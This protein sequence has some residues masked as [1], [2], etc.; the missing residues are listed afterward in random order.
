MQSD[1]I[2]IL[3]CLLSLQHFSSVEI[4]TLKSMHQQQ[5]WK[6]VFWVEAQSI[7]LNIPHLSA[8]LQCS[9]ILQRTASHTH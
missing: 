8:Y 3:Q 7:S 4:T 6:K 2:Y 9:K 1:F 5:I